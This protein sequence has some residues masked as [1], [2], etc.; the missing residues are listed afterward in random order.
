MIRLLTAGVRTGLV[1]TVVAATVPM[2]I[3]A[4][5][6]EPAI[7]VANASP[8]VGGNGAD[9]DTS[10]QTPPPARPAIPASVEVE[11][12]HLLTE[13]RSEV[14]DDRAKSIDRWLIAITIV[15]G[16]FAIVAVM[17]GYMGFSRF[18]EIETEAKNSIKDVTKYRDEAKRYVEE[19][20]TK[21][22]EILDINAETAADDPDK[23]RQAVKHVGENPEASLID[24]AIA[25]A[26]SLSLQQQQ[27]GKRDDAVEKWRAI[28][29]VAEKSDNDLAARAWFSIGYLVMDKSPEDCISAND[30]AIRLKPDF[31]EA[32]SNRGNAK[33]VLGR[34][35][36]AIA[37]YDEA[38]RLKPD[39]AKAYSNRGNAKT[40]LGRHVDAITD[41]DEA[42]R[43][44][45]DFAKAYS[46]RG[47]AKTALGRHVDAIADYDEAIRLKPDFAEVHSNR[48]NAKTALGR[49]VD[50]IADYDEAIRLKPDFA[51]AYSNRGN[52]KTALERYDDAITDCDEAIR[53][54]PDLAEA[55]S[56]RGGAKVALERYDDAII[57]CDEAI[58]LKSDFA[59][60]YYN[61]GAA[62]TKLGDTEGA[63]KDFETAL[64]RARNAGNADMVSRAEQSLRDLDADGG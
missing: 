56:N 26:V 64:E 25:D 19:I 14:L 33:T 30:K 35:V 9:N 40:A 36:D 20:K 5:T 37:D 63:R 2:I 42:I 32:Y 22:D 1:A 57:N 18:R 39:F 27:E 17:G 51:E 11:F 6:T 24:K 23:A 44:K 43:L 47:N 8:T 4:Q 10:A 21:R 61:R 45:P 58:R 60:A 62:K 54:K 38:I 50:A 34:H 41:C 55:H 46:N 12:Q 3:F 28:A 15:L 31:A 53:L 7:E 16:F 59:E 13:H 48:G 49:H 29:Q 52:A